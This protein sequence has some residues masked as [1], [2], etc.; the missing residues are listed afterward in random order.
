[1][2]LDKKLRTQ[3]TKSCA[4]Q[5][6]TKFGILVCF[7]VSFKDWKAKILHN[8]KFARNRDLKLPELNSFS[9]FLRGIP[10]FGNFL[11]NIFSGKRRKQSCLQ[12]PVALFTLTNLCMM[13]KLAN[14][15]CCKQYTDGVPFM[16]LVQFPYEQ[17][18][19]VVVSQLEHP[20]P[21][22]LFGL[23]SWAK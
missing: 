2:K 23:K 20:P 7:Q 17:L 5:I 19:Y 10:I 1:M 14:R 15:F 3:D 22:H 18:V 9:N 8:E 12:N 21:L 13:V 11:L 16:S 6:W 4:P